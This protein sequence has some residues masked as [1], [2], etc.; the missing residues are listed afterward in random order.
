MTV[1]FLRTSSK[2]DLYWYLFTLGSK[3]GDVVTKAVPF[4]FQQ[5][6]TEKY[7]LTSLVV[8]RS[9]KNNRHLKDCYI[10]ENPV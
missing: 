6:K 8:L 10:E 3:R 1:V 5:T 4:I 2:F 9:L 7:S